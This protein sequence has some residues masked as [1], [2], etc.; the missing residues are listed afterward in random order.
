MNPKRVIVW[1]H[2]L[3]NHTH[4]YIHSSYF[5]TFLSMGFETHWLDAKDSL[6]STS[7]DGTLFFCEDQAK[8]GLPIRNDCY[9]ITHSF[10]EDVLSDVPR[11]NI[12]R[13]HNFASCVK[14][15]ERIGDLTYY[16][17]KSRSLYQPWA[18]DLLPHEI[19]EITPRDF[20]ID[21]KV[22]YYVGSIY[23]E[24]YNQVRDLIKSCSESGKSL[25]LARFVTD[26]V[27]KNLTRKS[28]IVADMRGTHHCEVGYMPCRV[29]KAI[30]YGVPVIVNSKKI[31]EELPLPAIG[32]S[33]NTVE[34][35]IRGI[36]HESTVSKSQVTESMAHIRNNHTFVNRISNLL[37]VLFS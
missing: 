7:L 1:G 5:K 25:Q 2:K 9:Y 24:N 12:V 31:V 30:S 35:L 27:H 15:H 32:L 16:D 33:E 13:L 6:G 3:H 4:S 18:T 14:V 10:N 20:N 19:D 36:H 28:L 22:C 21:E 17:S 26:E 8:A 37:G 29:F 34:T 23:N 11:N